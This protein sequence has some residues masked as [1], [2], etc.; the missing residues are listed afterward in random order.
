MNQPEHKSVT[1]ATKR[2]EKK[3]GLKNEGGFARH[4]FMVVKVFQERPGI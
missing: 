1:Q 2:G 3:A 4:R